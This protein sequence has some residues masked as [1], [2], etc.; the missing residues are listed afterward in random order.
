MTITPLPRRHTF[1]RARIRSRNAD[2]RFKNDFDRDLAA[3]ARVWRML[4]EG[5]TRWFGEV[6]RQYR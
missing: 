4:R 2:H 3:M 6:G 1:D 5:A